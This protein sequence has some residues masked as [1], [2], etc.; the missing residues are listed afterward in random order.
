MF[1]GFAISVHIGLEASI[2]STSVI[3]KRGNRGA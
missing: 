1:A 2:A 3:S